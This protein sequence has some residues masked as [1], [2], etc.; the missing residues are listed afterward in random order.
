MQSQQMWPLII[1]SVITLVI[2]A[3]VLRG[4]KG[5]GKS[6]GAGAATTTASGTGANG[7][8]RFTLRRKELISSDT[9]L[10]SFEPNNDDG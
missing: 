4:R 8:R 10:L 6:K 9:A 5:W 3:V 7:G 2:G 1:T